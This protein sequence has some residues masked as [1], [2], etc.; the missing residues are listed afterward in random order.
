MLQ[1][2]QRK[3][4]VSDE[5]ESNDF[6]LRS[7]NNLLESELESDSDDEYVSDGGITKYKNLC[8]EMKIVPC[9]IVL[10]SLP[11]TSISLANYGISSNNVLALTNALKVT[12]KI[13]IKT[14]INEIKNY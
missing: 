10:K 5:L 4:A 1:S 9:S 11:T 6:L 13:K 7:D 8:H 12:F 3:D 14:K 2:T